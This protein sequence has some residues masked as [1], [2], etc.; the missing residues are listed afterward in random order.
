MRVLVTGGTGF[1]GSH[2]VAALRRG[3]HQVRLLVRSRERLQPALTP[4]GIDVGDIEVA[5]G[6]CADEGAVSHAVRGCDALL[7]AAASYTLDPRRQEDLVR[8]NSAAAQVVLGTAVDAGLDPVVHV[9][10]YVALLPSDTPLTTCTP[11]SRCARGYGAS[12]AASEEVARRH[13]AEGAPVVAAY[14]G[15]VVGPHDPY[16]GESNRLVRLLATS[17]RPPTFGLLPVVDV[18]D[19]AAAFATLFEAGLGPRRIM[20]TGHQVPMFELAR[21]SAAA[22]GLRNR[23][24]HLAPRAA[25]VMGA[26]GDLLARANVP[27]PI[28]SEP[29]RYALHYRGTASSQPGAAAIVLRSLDESL[30]DTVRWLRA[31]GHLERPDEPAEGGPR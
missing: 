2:S 9:S 31:A 16:L 14:P 17:R 12:K 28:G 13:Q 23:P 18:R 20:L 11:V 25:R 4:L 3:G 21:R 30:S 7:H 22:A 29:V 26:L 6:E 27:A 19:V 10:S 24:V 8:L 15:V 5:D 1:L